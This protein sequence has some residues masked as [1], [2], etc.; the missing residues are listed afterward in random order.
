MV[1]NEVV[2]VGRAGTLV[3]WEGGSAT[4]HDAEQRGFAVLYAAEQ[5]INWHSERV[6]G[7]NVLT[8]V[9][10][11]EVSLKPSNE[12]DVFQPETI[13]QIRVLKLVEDAAGATP[14]TAAGTAVPPWKYIVEIWQRRQ[15]TTK[16]SKAEWIVVETR[17]PLRL[18][19]PLPL[20]PFVFHGPRHS[21][22]DVD[23]VRF[24]AG[25]QLGGRMKGRDKQHFVQ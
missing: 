21:L 11:K 4:G 25:F 2:T 6:N 24:R 17:T 8:L 18:G 1:T 15:A 23:K 16:R 9:V 5:I 10:L 19:K 12:P 14:T 7:R 13:E 20:I 22:P 3:D